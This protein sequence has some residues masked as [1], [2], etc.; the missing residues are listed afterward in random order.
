M[1]R[2]VLR[3]RGDA[4]ELTELAR[5]LRAVAT[6]LPDPPPWF[7]ARIADHVRR[8]ERASADLTTAAAE[9]DRHAGT[10]VLH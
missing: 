3:L 2:T 4:A 9:L 5:R 8:C 6:G 1:K 10:S 7:S